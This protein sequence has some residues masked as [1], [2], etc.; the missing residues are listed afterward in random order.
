MTDPLYPMDTAIQNV[1]RFLSYLLPEN[2]V[3]RGGVI[4]DETAVSV[5][6]DLDLQLQSAQ[7]V[8]P[9]RLRGCALP[10]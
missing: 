3:L 7:K 10:F 8:S 2:I 6:F 1:V 9:N 5:H 4:H